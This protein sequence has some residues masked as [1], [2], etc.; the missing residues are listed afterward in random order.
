M[1]YNEP[2]GEIFGRSGNFRTPIVL[3][4]VAGLR[5]FISNCSANENLLKLPRGEV[6]DMLIVKTENNVGV[7]ELVS[8]VWQVQYATFSFIWRHLD[9]FTSYRNNPNCSTVIDFFNKDPTKMSIY[10]YIYIYNKTWY[11]SESKTIDVHCRGAKMYFVNL[12]K[13][14]YLVASIFVPVFTLIS[15]KFLPPFPKLKLN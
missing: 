14:T 15:F 3:Y 11:F 6:Y 10:V 5:W 4:M 2:W 1:K 9:P 12:L 8:K 13:I 7:T